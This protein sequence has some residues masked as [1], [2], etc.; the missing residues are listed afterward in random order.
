MAVSR[1]KESTKL[2][3][4]RKHHDY[5]RFNKFNYPRDQSRK[6]IIDPFST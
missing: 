3:S 1:L 2:K 5:L 6:T 4:I